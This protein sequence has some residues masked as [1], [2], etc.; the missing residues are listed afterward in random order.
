MS[1]KNNRHDS[2]EYSENLKNKWIIAV[3]IEY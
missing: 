1:N 3:E 2:L